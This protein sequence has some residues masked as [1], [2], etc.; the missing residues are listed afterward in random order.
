MERDRLIAEIARETGIR[1]DRGDPL[2]AAATIN[3][4][5]LDEALA[6]LQRAARVSGDQ[7]SA[8]CLQQIEAAKTA[9]AAL[10]TDAGAWSAERLREAA[11]AASNALIERLREE[12]A[13]AQHAGRIALGAVWAAAGIGA[14]AVAATA[15][16]WL[17]T[18]S[19]G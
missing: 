4:I 6:E 16:V 13:K 14:L 1:L 18:I 15:G 8:A 17:A 7:V 19:H 10:I 2:L 3:R 9:A 5:L 12:T 11:A